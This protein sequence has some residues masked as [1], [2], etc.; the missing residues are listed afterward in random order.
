MTGNLKI[1]LRV[2]TKSV[3]L[4]GIQNAKEGINHVEKQTKT[5][6]KNYGPSPTSVLREA[7]GM[8]NT[9]RYLETRFYIYL[10]KTH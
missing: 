9:Y 8:H 7:V 1:E 3:C 10:L 5:K 2:G 6:T 4:L